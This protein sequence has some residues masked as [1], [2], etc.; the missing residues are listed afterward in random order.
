[1]ANSSQLYHRNKP[2][3]NNL[4]DEETYKTKQL[5][6]SKKTFLAQIGKGP[7]EEQVE[8]ELWDEWLSLKK[9]NLG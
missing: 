2:R 3:T 5:V 4:I 7:L 1:M 6:N 9:K 8:L